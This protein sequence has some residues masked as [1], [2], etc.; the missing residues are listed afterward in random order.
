MDFLKKVLFGGLIAL[1]MGASMTSCG[2]DDDNEEYGTTEG[3]P[4]TGIY[5]ATHVI[6]DEDGFV[7]SHPI[8]TDE[9][10]M[11]LTLE[12]DNRCKYY[13]HNLDDYE[14][15]YD[16]AP[17]LYLENG[18]WVY[19]GTQKTLTISFPGYGNRVFS[20]KSWT[21]NKLVT[22]HEE[23]GCF[24]EFTWTKVSSVVTIK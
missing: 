18:T 10:N 9:L 11:H 13:T 20:V 3:A 14:D 2:S 7:E 21:N 16:A 1:C 19:N 15:G 22:Y 12:T 8:S 5:Q 6:S 4:Y 17:P 23:D 24:Y